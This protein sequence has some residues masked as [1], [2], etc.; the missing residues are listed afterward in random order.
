MRKFRQEL[1][2]TLSLRLHGDHMDI[3]PVNRRAMT[4]VKEG[5]LDC[6]E[7]WALLGYEGIPREPVEHLVVSLDN[8]NVVYFM[9]PDYNNHANM[10]MIQ[11]DTRRKALLSAVQCTTSLGEPQRI[12]LPAKLSDILMVEN[13]LK[14]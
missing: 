10:W 2:P 4:W 5:V 14:T 1:V 6:D 9:V 12:H 8:P 11:V 7:I 3:D 13:P